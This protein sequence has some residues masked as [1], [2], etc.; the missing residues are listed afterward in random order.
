M[1]ARGSVEEGGVR[2]CDHLYQLASASAAPARQMSSLRAGIVAI[3]SGY[4]N[5]VSEC[6]IETAITIRAAAEAWFALMIPVNGST[7]LYAIIGDP[8][9]HVRTPAVFNQ[10]FREAGI[11]AVCVPLHF[12]ADGLRAAFAALKALVNLDGF[13]VTAPHK[14][15]AVALCDDVVGEAKLVGALN[16]VRR[17]ADGRL[18]GDLFDGTGFVGGLRARGWEPAGRR[19][20]ILGAG[21]AASALAFALARAGARSITLHNRSA[22]KAQ[23]LARRLHSAYPACDVRAGPRDPRDHDLAINA[24][25]L[26]IAPGDPLPFDVSGLPPEAV[27]ADLIMIPE[28]TPL[29]AS[30]QQRGCLVHYGRHML[31][32]QLELMFGFL[33]RDERRHDAAGPPG[34]DRAGP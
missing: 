34:G 2:N 7:R 12:R 19:V 26:G 1:N 4:C 18:V 28:L 23:D 11:D 30:A 24:T 16:T 15:A 17:S 10:R 8:L 13:I 5:P 21:G 32:C 25:P 9:S 6:K 22:S 20:F 27:V 31:D 3:P 14:Q 33:Q 29:L